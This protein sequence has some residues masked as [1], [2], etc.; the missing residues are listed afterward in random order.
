MRILACCGVVMMCSSAVSTAQPTDDE[1]AK[2]AERCHQLLVRSVV[3]FYL[4]HC[5]D[6]EHGGYLEQLDAQGAFASGHGKFLTLQA[7]QLW[8]F[9]VLAVNG[10]RKDEALAAADSGYKFLLAHFR[11]LRNGGYYSRV[12]DTGEPTDTRKHAYHNAF[13]V[14]GLCAYYQASGNQQARQAALELFDVL[15]A[16]A[17]DRRY[18]GY[19]E[20][21]YA[22]WTPITDPNEP[23]YVGAIGTKTYNTH[24]HLLE[25]FSQLAQVSRQPRIARRLAELMT[26]N[27]V[28]VRHPDHACHIDGW[29]RDWKL[30]DQPRNLRASYGHD[31]ECAWLV[32]D[33]ARALDTPIEP[34]RGWAISLVDYSLR[35]GYDQTNGGFY[36][37]GAIGSGADDRQKVWWVESEAIVSMLEMYALT[38]DVRYYQAFN[39]TLNFIEQHQVATNEGGWWAARDADGS[40]HD[41]KSRTSTWQAGYHNGRALLRCGQ[42]LRHLAQKQSS[43]KNEG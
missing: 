5:V 31:L 33:A 29:T 7:R 24:L 11:D 14:Y 20:F 13:V 32:F 39:S 15:E 34:L 30:I 12:S 21:F 25:A 17:Y 40:V 18:G 41:N 10:I 26:I 19:Q 6:T 1:L 2:Q 36:N 43:K 8:L 38:E 42:L 16:N 22:D 9:S 4:P 23:A 35:H 28:T 27:T 37:T 3:D